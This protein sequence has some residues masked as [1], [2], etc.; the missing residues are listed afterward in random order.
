MIAAHADEV[1]LMQLHGFSEPLLSILLNVGGALEVLFG[2]TIA[3]VYR[4]RW[5]FVLSGINCAIG[6]PPMPTQ[7]VIAAG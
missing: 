7:F 1:S 3:L 5:P 4:W 2:L 6:W